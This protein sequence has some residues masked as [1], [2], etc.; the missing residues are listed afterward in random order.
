M[1]RLEPSLAR[2][3]RLV[4]YTCT[5]AL[6]LV[7]TWYFN[8]RYMAAHDGAF[9]ITPFIEDAFS[10]DAAGSLSSDILVAGLVGTFWMVSEARRLSMRHAW[11]YVVV[12]GL[13][14]FAAAFPLFLFV[15]ELRLAELERT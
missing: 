15:R 10:N 14:A 1:S 8:L 6:G 13:V 12:G 4:F 9:A 2:K 5:F 11:I 3:L 7:S